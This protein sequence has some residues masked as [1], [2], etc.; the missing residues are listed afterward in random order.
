MRGADYSEPLGIE[1][2]SISQAVQ[3]SGLKMRTLQNLAAQGL[4][5]G[6]AAGRPLD[7]R[8]CPA[9]AMGAANTGKHTAMPKN[10]S[11]RNGVYWGRFQVAGRI[12]RK[13]LHVRVEPKR[14]AE[15]RAIQA[16]E[17]LRLEI[18]EQ[19]HHGIAPPEFGK[20][21]SSRGMM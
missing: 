2:V 3:I 12:Y 13:S 10:I 8:Y 14:R 17:R 21:L 15:A 18:E 1:R 20:M 7:L 16:L 11:I 19:I 5:P 9:A 4:I 6:A